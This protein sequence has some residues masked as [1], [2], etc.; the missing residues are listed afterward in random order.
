M[1]QDV[2]NL[3]GFSEDD[4]DTV[5][6]LKV[7]I[8]SVQQRLLLLIGGTEVPDKLSY[9]V[10]EVSVARYNRIGSEGISSHSVEGESVSFIEDDFAPY[11][12]DIE[13]YL[14]SI[15]GGTKGVVRFI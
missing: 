1:L 6:R 12:T 13:A 7:I 3:L 15:S 8:A 4:I 5:E 9:I 10:T 11:M 2:L 14:T